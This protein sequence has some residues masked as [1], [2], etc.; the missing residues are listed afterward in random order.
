MVIDESQE[1]EVGDEPSKCIVPE[2]PPVRRIQ[3]FIDQG[4][5]R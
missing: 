3:A 2:R 1:A 5:L 4:E